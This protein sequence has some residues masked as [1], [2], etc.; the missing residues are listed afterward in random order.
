MKTKYC[1]TPE[2]FFGKGFEPWNG[3]FRE[4]AETAINASGY[5]KWRIATAIGVS[6]ICFYKYFRHPITEEMY[7]RILRA[8]DEESI[9]DEHPLPNDYRSKARD[10]IRESGLPFWKV[11]DE[12]GCCENSLRRKFYKPMEWETY[13]RIIRAIEIG[14][15]Q[16]A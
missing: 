11:A 6:D 13:A 2:R 1:E 4:P 3:D 15:N 9:R 5:P 8:I 12:F 7:L 10:A 14:L 16:E